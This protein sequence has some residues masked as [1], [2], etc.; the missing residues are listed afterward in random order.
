MEKKYYNDEAWSYGNLNR[1]NQ[2]NPEIRLKEIQ[3]FLD[4]NDIYSRFKQH[5][6]ARKYSPI[7]VYKKR[8]LFQADVVFFTDSDMV[9]AN[10]GYKYL[11][12]CIDCF[13]K[14]AWVFP[15]MV[16]NCETIMTYFKHIIKICGKKPDRLN[17]DRG[18]ELI[19]KK[20]EKYLSDLKIFH[21]LSYSLRKCPII[22]RFNLTFQNLLYKI[23]AKNKN[24]KWT[25]YL[26]QAMSIYVNRKHRIIGM[27]PKQA[28]EENNEAIVRKNLLHFFHKRIKKKTNPKFSVNDTVRIW[29]KRRTFQRGYDENY[30]IEYFTIL[31]VKNNLPFPRY[32][33]Q[34]SNGEEIIG[35][36]FEDELVKFNPNDIFDIQILKERKKGREKQ[37]FVHYVGYPNSMNEW[38][39]KKKLV[40]N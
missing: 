10:N 25:N 15:L 29:K 17:S 24:L 36:F 18:S 1:I 33:L 9:K 11:F 38:I 32:I 22:E 31:K 26:N 21:Y 6:K 39:S 5:R 13:S 20:F 19:C 4:K 37:Y 28:E 3:N 27:S 14:M 23:M 35:S 30:S 12:T 34:D 2:Y 16:N 8:E 40:K 7:Y